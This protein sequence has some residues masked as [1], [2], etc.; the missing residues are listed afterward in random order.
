M[1][2]LTQE[3]T[4]REVIDVDDP[5]NLRC[6]PCWGSFCL[7]NDADDE[8]H[9]TLLDAVDA[10]E[11]RY[12]LIR[13][14]PLLSRPSLCPTCLHRLITRASSQSR[15]PFHPLL[16]VSAAHADFASDVITQGPGD[17]EQ[18][19]VPFLRGDHSVPS[20][21]ATETIQLVESSP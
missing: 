14:V 18:D 15:P 21:K 9:Q 19:T 16:L 10:A 6:R 8:V 5:R 11:A 17:E 4:Y 13:V 3:P 20:R 1:L 12:S 2:P 7:G